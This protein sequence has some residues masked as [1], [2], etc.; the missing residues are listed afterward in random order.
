MY[1]VCYKGGMWANEN[2]L[3][4]VADGR[5]CAR[6]RRKVLRTEAEGSTPPPYL[7][8]GFICNL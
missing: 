7:K 1:T 5:V 2:V 3:E 4:G 6:V 8:H